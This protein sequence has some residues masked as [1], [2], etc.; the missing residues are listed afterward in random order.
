MTR[1]HLIVV[2][3]FILRVHNF[4]LHEQAQHACVLH[5]IQFGGQSQFL[6]GGNLER[7]GHH[8]VVGKTEAVQE[9]QTVLLR[10]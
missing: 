9:V 4:I 7:V 8:L 2:H 3:N 10:W 1:P 6:P 5:S